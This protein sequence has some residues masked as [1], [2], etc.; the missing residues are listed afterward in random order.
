MNTPAAAA[1]TADG[2]ILVLEAGNSRI[3]A[4][5]TCA[6]P[7][8]LFSKQPRQYVLNLTG[9]DSDNFEYLDM[10]VEYSGYT[11]VLTRNNQQQGKYRQCSAG[12]R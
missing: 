3:H 2:V 10:A 7:V 1:N 11:Y 8:R 5:D 4:L 9:T 12:R 6:N